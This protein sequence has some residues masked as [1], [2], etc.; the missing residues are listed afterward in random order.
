MTT[1]LAHY[2]LSVL[3][4]DESKCGSI[5]VFPLLPRAPAAAAD[6]ATS[7]AIPMALLMSSSKEVRDGMYVLLVTRSAAVSRGPSRINII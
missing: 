7:S 5:F 4:T 2:T 1:R 6:G 3:S